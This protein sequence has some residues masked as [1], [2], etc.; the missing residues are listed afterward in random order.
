[1][2]TI[3]DTTFKITN[4]KLYVPIVTV[5]SKNSTK[6]VKLL[7]EGFKT[8]VYWNEFQRKIESR[9][10]ENN[11]LTRFHLDASFLEVRRLFVV[12]FG[13]TDNVD[14]KVERNSHRKCFLPRVNIINY[15][16]LID[17]RNFYDQSANDQIKKYDEIRKTS[18]G[19][20]EDYTTG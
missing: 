18:T 8:P 7:E 5:S 15:N 12:A 11:N 6:L 17:G 20:G 13:N 3:A 16:V 10:L 2:A 19:Q 9:N 14:K 4:K 1:M